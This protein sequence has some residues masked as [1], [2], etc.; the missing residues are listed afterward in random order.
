MCACPIWLFSVAHW[1][2]AFLVQSIINDFK[3][4]PVAHTITGITFVFTFHMLCISIVKVLTSTSFLI[5]FVTWNWSV[6]EQTDIIPSALL[7]IMS[8]VYCGDPLT[9]KHVPFLLHTASFIPSITIL[10]LYFPWWGLELEILFSLVSSDW[11]LINC[12]TN[13][14]IHSFIHSFIYSF[15][16]SVWRQPL[17]NN[18]V[19]WPTTQ[20]CRIT[21]IAFIMFINI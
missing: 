7:W 8:P 3:T 9:C 5:T 20:F 2:R 12:L 16:D 6:H 19:S 17:C 4:V 11:F 21:F 10:S 13:S 1:Y 18:L 14:F 15:L